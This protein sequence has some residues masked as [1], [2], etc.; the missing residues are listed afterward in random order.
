[1]ISGKLYLIWT[2][3][4]GVE[5]KMRLVK[6]YM[7]DAAL[8]HELNALTEATFYFN[9]ESWVVNGYFEGDYI[10]YSFEED[11]KIL[12]NVSA[13]LMHFVQNG[14]KRNY[15]QMLKKIRME[16]ILVQH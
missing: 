11:G 3:E 5:D 7:R 13:N 8:R 12:S 4:F 15:I 6:D 14:E 2:K 9:F 10:P 16:F 1:M